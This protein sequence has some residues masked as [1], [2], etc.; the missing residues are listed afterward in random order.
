VHIEQGPGRSSGC[1]GERESLERGKAG[2][3]V[4]NSRTHYRLA[5]ISLS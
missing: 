1:V 5:N 3:L 4:G 2:Y